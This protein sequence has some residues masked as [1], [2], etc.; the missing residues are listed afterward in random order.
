MIS[1]LYLREAL[2]VG[3]G[4]RII[5]DECGC[6]PKN[7]QYYV[8]KY[9][10]HAQVGSKCE[11]N[12]S[13]IIERYKQGVSTVIL[14]Q[15]N[16]VSK[17]TIL[18]ILIKNGICRRE[19]RLVQRPKYKLNLLHFKPVDAIGAYYLGL[20]FADGHISGKRKNLVSLGLHEKDGDILKQFKVDIEYPNMI[21]KCRKMNTIKIENAEF[22]ELMSNFGMRPG[23]EYKINLPALSVDMRVHFVRGFLDGDGCVG[24]YGKRKHLSFVFEHKSAADEFNQWIVSAT[25]VKLNGPYANKK[26]MTIWSLSG[27]CRKAKIVADW[28]YSNPI[29]AFERKMAKYK[30][31]M[32]R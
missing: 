15:D 32:D 7:V 14:A 25:G 1:E 24:L 31:W 22:H 8:R 21:Y 19:S 4:Y 3:K 11:V 20:M 26:I 23:N 29:R 2:L 30:T 27:S 12:V 17:R 9:K 10:L 6:T 16:H 28:I 5:A 18:N 13:E